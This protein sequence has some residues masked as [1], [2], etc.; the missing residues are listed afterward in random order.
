MD[1]N[2]RSSRTPEAHDWLYG[3]ETPHCDYQVD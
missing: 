3:H 1:L 2:V